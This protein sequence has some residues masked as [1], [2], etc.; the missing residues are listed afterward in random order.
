MWSPQ[1]R[2]A[3][4]LARKRKGH[5]TSAR[6]IGAKYTIKAK[7]PGNH[8]Q[9]K[10][11]AKKVAKYTAKAGAA[12]AV[13]AAGGIVAYGATVAAQDAYHHSNTGR[14]RRAVKQVKQQYKRGGPSYRKS[15]FNQKQ[16]GTE[17]V[18]HKAG[19]RQGYRKQLKARR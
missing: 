1:A 10:A 7:H 12:G 4:A 5:T 6:H 16:R 17:K 11:K 9:F 2:K 13:G 19:F 18:M 8:S 14:K 3:A 15:P